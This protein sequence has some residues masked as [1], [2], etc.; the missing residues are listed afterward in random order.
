MMRSKTLVVK[1]DRDI[2]QLLAVTMKKA[3]CV[4]VSGDSY[5]EIKLTRG[6]HDGLLTLDLM[7]LGT[8]GVDLF[9]E[10]DHIIGLELGADDCVFK[11]FKPSELLL[12]VRVILRCGGNEYKPEQQVFKRAGLEIDFESYRVTLDGHEIVLTAAEFKLLAELVNNRGKSP[13]T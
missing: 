12:R 7:L 5:E 2:A 11:R 8:D 10:I 6:R 3:G 4:A 9:E 1:D 13:E